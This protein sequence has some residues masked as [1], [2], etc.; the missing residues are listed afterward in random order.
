MRVGA[1][2]VLVALLP[3]SMNSLKNLLSDKRSSWSYEVHFSIFCFLDDAQEMLKSLATRRKILAMAEAYLLQV[4]SDRA[5]AAW[6]AGDM[7]GDHWDL[8]ESMP[9]LMRA[10]VG[11][12]FAAGRAGAQ[13]GLRQAISRV[14][15]GRRRTLANL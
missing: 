7:L 5:S 15:V 4:R 2:K 12:R 3:R 6:M 10:T 1:V 14:S 9:V 8:Q 11:A 13:H